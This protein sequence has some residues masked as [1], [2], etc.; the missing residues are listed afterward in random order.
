M[1]TAPNGSTLS[2][3]CHK[4][5]QICDN[6]QQR[7]LRFNSGVFTWDIFNSFPERAKTMSQGLMFELVKFDIGVTPE[8]ILVSH[9]TSQP[10]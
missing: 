10:S 6:T 1:I 5:H 7:Y 9:Q 3:P 4:L 8:K 2:P